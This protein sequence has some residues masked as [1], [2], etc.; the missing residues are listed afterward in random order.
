MNDKYAIN[1]P[2]C[3]TALFRAGGGYP[4]IPAGALRAARPCAGN[5][6]SDHAAVGDGGAGEGVSQLLR[7]ALWGMFHS[8]VLPLYILNII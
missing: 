2:A 8:S 1:P 7:L 4:Y 3:H 5:S 6:R